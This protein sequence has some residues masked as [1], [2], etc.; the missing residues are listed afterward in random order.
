M[1]T[2]PRSS[3]SALLHLLR[4]FWPLLT[5]ATLLGVLGG[6]S[7]TGLL[8]AINRILHAGDRPG[9]GLLLAFAGLCAL[10]LAGSVLSD[11]GTNRIGQRVIAR[12]RK[13]LGDRILT[14]PID[15]LERYRSHRL[16]PVLTHD[17]DTISD[18]AFV[19]A[20]LAVSLSVTLGS[21]VYLALLSWPMFLATAA[22]ILIGSAVQYIA[23]G[24]GIEGFQEARAHEDELQKHYRSLAE[25]AKE[26]RIN[27]PR[28]LRLQSEAL[29]GT[30]DRIC[31]VQIR[32]ITL[33]VV[34]KGFGSTLFFIV[35]GVALGVE[36][37]W[38]STD[39]GTLSGFILVLLYMKGPLEHLIGTLPIVSRAQVAFRRIAELS[40]AFASPEPHLLMK[41]GSPPPAAID[42]LELRAARYAYPPAG[43]GE[44]PFVL[45]PVSLRVGRGEILFIVGEN[46][47][48]KTTLI[49]MLLG[50]YAPQDG[51][52]L[53]NGK[54][55]TPETRDDYRQLFTTIFADYF[56]FDD[57]IQ[58]GGNVPQEAQAYLE[59]LEIA[60]KVTLVDGVFSTTDLSTGQ[61][62]RLA[63]LQAWTEG[64]PVLVFDEWAADQDPA[65]RRIFY[66]ELLPSLKA[67]GKTIIVISHDDRYFDVADHLLRLTAG[68]VAQDEF[69]R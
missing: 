60:H 58:A 40:A 35:I 62:K 47:C 38:P 1:P 52:I 20:P 67:M 19:F 15:Q 45:G 28:R 30:I 53:L 42:S 49:K 5:A 43:P 9:A 22:A 25:G 2:S 44:D 64:R 4:P 14:A 17:V 13:D 46:G 63:L 31:E 12:L 29:R 32:S 26:L 3:L 56:L 36:A 23:R 21:L 10:A 33:F 59:R 61:R 39:R 69:A 8:A 50:L 57:L 27:R 34:A 48:G 65:F 51:D 11:I 18:F 54:P 68:M 66:T 7:V 24:R 55:V 16:I 41:D 6:L 37:L